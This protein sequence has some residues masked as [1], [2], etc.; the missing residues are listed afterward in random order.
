MSGQDTTADAPRGPLGLLKHLTLDQWEALWQD[1]PP[2]AQPDRGTTY[3]VLGLYLVACGV[4]MANEYLTNNLHLYLPE[5]WWKGQASEHLW[6][7]CLWAWSLTFFYVVPSALYA[8]WAFGLRLRD[9][10][11]NARGLLK[12]A[13]LYL[14]FFFVVLPFVVWLS[15]D[16]HFMR[17]YP[18]AKVAGKSWLFLAIWMVSYGAQFVGVEFFYRGFMLFGPLRVVG[19]WVV[20]IMVIPYCMLHFQKP[21]LESVGS[22]IAG[23]TLG[24]VALRTGSIYAGVLIHVAVAWSMDLL[25]LWH[26]G[27]LP[28]LLGW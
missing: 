20:P 22:V 9:L 21:G 27:D 18:L 10:G 12:H 23:T 15:D 26:R 1:H 4:L 8:R 28:R 19:P 17:T 2:Q 7:K 24:I 6:R 14:G 11:Y 25:S 5:A 16:P 13:P 3:K